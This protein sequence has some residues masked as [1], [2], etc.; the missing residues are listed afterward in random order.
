ML[1]GGDAEFRAYRVGAR[2]GSRGDESNP[3]T[4]DKQLAIC[5][6]AAKAGT[7]TLHALMDRHPAVCVTRYKE[8]NFFYRDDLLARGYGDYLR[9]YF[10]S[11]PGCELLFEADPRYMLHPKCIDRI[12]EG[13]PH[14]RI[15][16]MLRNPIER[17][18]S[19]YVYR[20][21]YGRHDQS[22]EEICGD[23]P[24]LIKAGDD[25][26]GEFGF[27][28]RSRYAGQIEHIYARFPRGQV[29][30]MLFERLIRDQAHEFEKLQRWLGLPVVDVGAAWENESGEARSLLVAKVLYHPGYAAL[31][32]AVRRILPFRTLRNAISARIARLNLRR[33]R[34]SEKPTLDPALRARLMHD[35]SGDIA[36]TAEL[37]GLDLSVWK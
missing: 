12:A 5:V 27:L 16:V 19:Q 1:A 24:E 25:A 20:V 13:F 26:L 3:M 34:R 31:R 28:A 29:Y 10:K 14:A 9:S 32:G 33:L 36:R 23:E 4:P 22:F 6:G 2:G 21:A 7:T 8:T 18:Y 17:A 11:T 35:L 37:T 15:I 30:F